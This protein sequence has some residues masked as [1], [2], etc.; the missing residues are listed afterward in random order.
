MQFY[1]IYLIFMFQEI[2]QATSRASYGYQCFKAHKT[3]FP[4]SR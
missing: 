1:F 4:R 2:V 3:Q